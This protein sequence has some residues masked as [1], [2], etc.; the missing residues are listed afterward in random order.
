MESR[1]VTIIFKDGSTA[2]FEHFDDIYEYN[3]TLQVFFHFPG[4][5]YHQVQYPTETVATVV[6][7]YVDV[8]EDWRGNEV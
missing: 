1:V 8:M 7:G 4:E 2:T 6:K 3:G 5:H